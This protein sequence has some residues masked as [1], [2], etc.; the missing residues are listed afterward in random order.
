MRLIEQWEEPQ[1]NFRFELSCNDEAARTVERFVDILVLLA[2]TYCRDR[3]SDRGSS[4]RCHCYLPQ[5]SADRDQTARSPRR[6][7]LDEY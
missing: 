3:R 4:I 7:L 1:F 5:G 6:I 2:D